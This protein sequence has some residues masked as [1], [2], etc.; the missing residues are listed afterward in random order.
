M[1]GEHGIMK[2]RGSWMRG[3][4]DIP[5]MPIV[6]PASVLRFWNQ[7]PLLEHDLHRAKRYIDDPD[8]D[9]PKRTLYTAHET[10]ECSTKRRT[11]HNETHNADWFIRKI[12]EVKETAKAISFDIETYAG[13]ITVF[14]IADSPYHAISIPFTG[15]FSPYDEARLVDAIREL[16]DTDM[17]KIAHNGVYDCTYL[18]EQWKVQVRG[19]IWDTMLMHHSV[20]SEM[21]HSLAFCTSWYTDQP[22]YKEMAKEADTPVY[23]NRHWEYNALDATCTF[24][25]W[26]PLLDDMEEYATTEFYL[27][28]Y[29]P[30]SSRLA[31]IQRRGIPLA[32]AVRDAH[33]MSITNRLTAARHEIAKRAGTDLNPSSPAQLQK[34]LYITLGLPMQRDRVSGRPTTNEAALRTLRRKY[35]KEAGDFVKLLLEVRETEKLRGTY[36]KSKLEDPDGRVRTSYNIAGSARKADATGGTET[37]RL[38]SSE[39]LYGRGGN[40]QNIPKG[41]RDMFVAPKGWLMWQCDMSSAESYIVA[42]D[43]G[44]ERMLDVLTSHRLYSPELPDKLLYHEAIGEI[45]SGLPAAQVTG[46]LREL[47]KRVGHGWNYNMG[48]ITLARVVNNEMPDMPFDMHMAQRCYNALNGALRGVIAWRDTV[49]GH[50]AREK[51]LRNCFGRLRVFFGRTDEA[52]YREAFAFLPQSEVS[53]HLNSCMVR[54]EDEYGDGPI[55]MVVGQVH[56][57]ILGLVRPDHVD[58]VKA[59]VEEIMTSPLPRECKGIQLRIPCEFKVGANWKEVS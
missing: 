35:P 23:A 56:D 31:R 14:G 53:D 48:V 46:D 22:Y 1:T 3:I 54:L 6:H 52:T 13:T 33:M 24:E 41:I 39:N 49:R 32:T 40:L 36:L 26:K 58:V 8:W 21:R 30:L 4:N 47:A 50:I 34:F 11:V 55:A 2:W 18:A 20:F 15:R 43:S 16:M 10:I 37:G 7:L 45:I 59:R 19:F 38:S 17:P 25:I 57:S 28:Y 12:G 5:C 9:S 51:I 29:V 44:D 42:W 27:K